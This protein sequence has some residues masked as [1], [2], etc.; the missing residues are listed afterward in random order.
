MKAVEHQGDYPSHLESEFTPGANPTWHAWDAWSPEVEFCEFVGHLAHMLAPAVVIETGVGVGRITRHLDLDNIAAYLGYESDPAWRTNPDV[1]YQVLDT[2]SVNDVRSADLVILD[3]EV[4]LRC[5]ELEVWALHGK[6][7]SVC[8]CH[9]AG[10]QHV[11]IRAAVLR[12]ARVVPG[13][14][15]GNPRGGWLAVHP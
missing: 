14:F 4:Q 15:L 6:R 3:S 7:R 13:A 1:P 9:D 2:F 11:A 10:P 8:V 5:F 12:A